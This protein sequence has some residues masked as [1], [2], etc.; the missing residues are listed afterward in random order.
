MGF[1]PES[2]GH[3]RLLTEDGVGSC[4]EYD[5]VGENIADLNFHFQPARHNAVSVVELFLRR[6]GLRRLVFET[7][8]LDLMCWGATGW[9]LI[10]YHLGPGKR[11]RDQVIRETIYGKQWE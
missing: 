8:V 10:W 9:Y 6:S 1:D 3:L 11:I 5:V 4:R 2:I 7:R